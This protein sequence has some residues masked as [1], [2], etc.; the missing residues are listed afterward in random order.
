MRLDHLLSKEHT[1]R[2]VANVH[3]RMV[4][5]TSGI[6]DDHVL[7]SLLG[8]VVVTHCL[9]LVGDGVKHTVGS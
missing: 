6:V 8:G 1:P 4:V 3:W 2:P 9:A 7:S 5:F